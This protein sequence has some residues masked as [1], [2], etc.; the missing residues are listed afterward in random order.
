[1]GSIYGENIK[2]SLFG[3]S[4]GKCIGATIDG[5][6]SGFLVNLNEMKFNLLRRAPG[7]RN[8]Y[9]S[10]RKEADTPEIISGLKN[11]KTTGAP[12]CII[13][14]NNSYKLNNYKENQN[15]PRP[16]HCDYTAKIR[17][18]N[19][20][21]FFGSGHLSGRLTA[22]FVCCG[23]IC[24]Q[25]LQKKYNI[26]I[27]SRI[28]MINNIYDYIDHENNIPKLIYD[29]LKHRE[30][31][32]IN[33]HIRKNILNSIYKAKLNKD[34][35]GGIIE[36]AIFGLE[37]GIGDPIFNTI[38]SKIS[39]LMFAIPGAKGIE[40][41]SAFYMSCMNASNVNDQFD[42]NINKKIITK[43]NFNGGINGGI[44]NGMPI[45]FKIAIKPT[46]SIAKTQ[47]TLNIL[48]NKQC[49]L[50][51][52]GDHDPCIVIRAIPIIENLSAIAITDLLMGAYGY[53]KCKI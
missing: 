44:S 25:Y 53:K 38:E 46:S 5:F 47:Y 37:A 23:N 39:S 45:I 22:L 8:L 12:I 16:S 10:N 1:M 7:S 21:D 19:F 6:P 24:K 20:N 34:S 52:T 3:E 32:L 15:I 26:D 50:N 35:V 14:N 48:E 9:T 36:C 29:K 17:Y 30:I 27:Y 51:I 18:K 11:N 31:P 13:I 40:F 28:F 4:H 41:G 2:I 42:L 49:K 33:Y 43:T